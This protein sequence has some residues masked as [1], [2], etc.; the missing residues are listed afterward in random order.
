M[1]AVYSTTWCGDC[2]RLKAQLNQEGIEYQ[3]IDIE[4]DPEAERFVLEVNGGVQ[5][6]PTVVFDDGSVLVEPTIVQVKEH[7]ARLAGRR[8]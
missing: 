5:W 2:H 6:I 3:A 1:L 7:L 8:G 4:Q